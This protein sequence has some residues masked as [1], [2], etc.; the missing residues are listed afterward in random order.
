MPDPDVV[1]RVLAAA[2]ERDLI[3]LTAGSFAQVVRIIPPLV[4]T[5]DEVDQALGILVDSLDAAAA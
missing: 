2:L 5:P 1:K 4:T 3:L